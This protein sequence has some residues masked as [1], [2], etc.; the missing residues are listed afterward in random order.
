M[1]LDRA[2]QAA[3][4]RLN[5]AGIDQP[6]FEA[7][8][9][10]A[11]LLSA[12]RVQLRAFPERELDAGLVQDFLARVDRRKAREPTAHI[13]GY[14]DFHRYRFLASPAALIPRPETELIVDYVLEELKERPPQPGDRVLDLCC[15]SGCIGITILTELDAREIPVELVLT[16]LSRDALTLARK[17][18]VRVA[19]RA[20]HRGRLYQG[21]LEQALPESESEAGFALIVCNPPYIGRDEAVNLAPEVRDHEPE[22]ALFHHDPPGLYMKV[23]EAAARLLTSDG[24]L[25]LELGPRFAAD[26]LERAQLVFE[27]CDLRQD[28][29]GLDRF[30]IV[31]KPRPQL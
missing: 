14:R 1:R 22:L 17:N 4:E 25:I 20:A 26:I 9:L 30:L 19:G 21:D 27:E 23:F 3:A 24:T 5:A 8:V 7:E 2:L 13:L 16:D 31:R 15:G 29:A 12:D 11:D 18:L 6:R 10:L 28:Y